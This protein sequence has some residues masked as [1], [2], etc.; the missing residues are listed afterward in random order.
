MNDQIKNFSKII[1]ESLRISKNFH[2][3]G[4]YV[5]LLNLTNYAI[6]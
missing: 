6:E 5:N 3:K 4:I 2:I 1:F